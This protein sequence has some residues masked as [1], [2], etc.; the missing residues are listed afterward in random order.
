MIHL[1]NSF[2][3]LLFAIVSTGCVPQFKFT[4]SPGQ[5]DVLRTISSI[6]SI[7]SIP[8]VPSVQPGQSLLVRLDEGGTVEAAAGQRYV[9]A[10]GEE[11]VEIG[12]HPSVRAA[13]LRDGIWVG[14]PNIFWTGPG[15]DA[16]P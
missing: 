12:G 9:S 2:S 16:R 7:S 8:S 10:L 1:K 15:V 11:C 14:L 6:S 4:M 3:C 5:P 13:C